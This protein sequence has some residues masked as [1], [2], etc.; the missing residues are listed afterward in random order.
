MAKST[1]HIQHRSA[2]TVKE[3]AELLSISKP[4]IYRYI[5]T[6]QLPSYRIGRRRLIRREALEQFQKDLE[7]T[8]T[9]ALKD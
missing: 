8:H 9:Q 2:L 1:I 5:H 3:T 7:V 4:V 6:G